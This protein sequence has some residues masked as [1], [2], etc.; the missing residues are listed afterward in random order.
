MNF[1]AGICHAAKKLATNSPTAH[2]VIYQAHFHATI[3]AVYQC[4]GNEVAYRI[5]F[6]DI[7]FYMHVVSRLSYIIQ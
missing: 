2:I 4:I 3:Y 5:V 7:G 6:Y 1:H